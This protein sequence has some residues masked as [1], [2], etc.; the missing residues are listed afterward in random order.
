MASLIGRT[1]GKY[2][3]TE[4]LGRGG[5]AE[6]Y[7]AHHPQ[8]DRYVTIKVLHSYLAEGEDFLA[9][10]QREARAVAALRHPHIVQ[11][12]DFDVQDGTYY[13]VMEFIDGGTLQGRMADLA[14]E[15]AYLPLAQVLG[16]L[17]QVA[18]ALDYAHKKGIIHRDIKPSNILL[19]TSGEAYLT[20]FG[21]ARMVSATQFTATGALIGTPTYM[22]P[23][24]ALGEELTGASDIYSLGIILF[25]SLTGKAPFTSD[26]TPLAVIHKHVHE[27]PPKPSSLRPALAG[28]LEAVVL[29]TLEKAPEQRFL[30]AKELAQALEKSCTPDII[31]RVDEPTSQEIASIANLET[32]VDEQPELARAQLPTEIMG[33]QTR[34]EILSTPTPAGMDGL[35]TSGSKADTKE[36]LPATKVAPEEKPRPDAI[37]SEVNAKSIPIQTK[38]AQGEPSSSRGDKS[39]WYQRPFYLYPL[40]ATGS[41]G[42]VTLIALMVIYGLMSNGTT[43]P[44]VTSQPTM[45]STSTSK[46][47]ATRQSVI[48]EPAPIATIDA[49]PSVYDNFNNPEYDGKFNSNQWAYE[50]RNPSG[51]AIQEDGVL[52]FAQ[53]GTSQTTNLRALHYWEYRIEE[54]MFFEARL[55]IDLTADGFVQLLLIGDAIERASCGLHSMSDLVMAHCWTRTDDPGVPVAHGS[56]HTVRI[57]VDTDENKSTFFIDDEQ[58]AVDH[59]EQSVRGSLIL[60]SIQAYA[61]AERVEDTRAVKGYVDDVRVGPLK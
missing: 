20:D 34:A 42:L 6:V 46:P 40:I 25:E 48:I 61:G 27:P 15:G 32:L 24:Q 1:L 35:E 10:F 55:K 7:K 43:T 8:L 38:T 17:S 11:I 31:A 45:P 50:V 28:E 57:E 36:S 12:H 29:K 53:S 26:T 3:L 39:S 23:E 59:Y 60:F 21:I 14:R 13:M 16:I 49:D 54:P 56:W 18:G 44:P 2:Q 47:A 22:S 41:L 4:L 9:R 30:S 33:E 19:N 37:Q 5:M 58:L 52:V 51:N